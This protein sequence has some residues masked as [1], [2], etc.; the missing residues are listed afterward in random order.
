ML[1]RR[2]I[3]LCCAPW[4]KEWLDGLDG[5]VRFWGWDWGIGLMIDDTDIKI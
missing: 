2:L 1:L 3:R 5:V 4:E